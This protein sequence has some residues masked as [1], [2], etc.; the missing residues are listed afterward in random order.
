MNKQQGK[1]VGFSAVYL[2]VAIA[3]AGLFQQLVFQP[4][5]IRWTEV[6]Y[7]QFIA[8]LNAGEISEVHLTTDRIMY[9]WVMA[10]K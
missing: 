1:K 5:V 4:M 7:S 2:L 9:T 3:L 10:K 6:P 8:Q